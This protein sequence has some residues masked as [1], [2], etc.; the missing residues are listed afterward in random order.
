MSLTAPDASGSEHAI[1]FSLSSAN[2]SNIDAAL[3]TINNQLL[4]SNDTTLQQIVAV[5]DQSN[6]ADGVRF[7]SSL[8]NFDVSLGSTSTTGTASQ[9]QS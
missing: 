7:V 3:Q 5:K 1:S 6:G 9:P 8:P 2:A 4:T